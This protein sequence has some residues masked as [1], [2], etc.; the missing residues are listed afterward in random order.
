MGVSDGIWVTAYEVTPY[1]HVRMQATIQRYVDQ[2]ISKTVNLPAGS[3]VEDVEDAYM[4]GWE[5]GLKGMAIYVDGSRHEQVL[6][7]KKAEGCPL[8]GTEIVRKEGC[9]EC[10]SCGWGLCG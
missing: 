5:L 1:E 2:S 3:T 4:L 9:Q 7:V 6:Y 10:P 8:C